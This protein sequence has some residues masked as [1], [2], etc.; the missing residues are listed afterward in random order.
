MPLRR[1]RFLLGFRVC[2]L[3][4]LLAAPA[5]PLAAQTA[6]A[7]PDTAL[8][9]FLVTMGQGDEVWEKFGHNALWIHDPVNG[10]ELA[11]N[12]GLFDF[13][14][15][16][17]WGRFAKGNW[18][19]QIGS[20]DALEMIDYYR[21]SNRS[22]W[23][24][25][26]NLTATQKREL[27]QFLQWNDLPGNRE[28]PYNYFW[29]NCS[30]RVRDALDRVLGGQI[31]AATQDSATGTTYRWHSRRLIA[32][33]KLGYTGMNAGLGP[34]A[35]HPISVW[36]EMFIPMQLQA[37]LRG[38]RVRDAAGRSVPLVAGEQQIFRAV[39]RPPER[40]APPRWIPAYLGIGVVL[41]GVL[42]GLGWA[43]GRNGLARWG[44]AALAALWTLLAGFGGIVLGLLWML[45]DHVAAHRNHNLL[46]FDPLALLLVFLIPAFAYGAR[47]AARPALWFT[48]TVAALSALGLLLKVFPAWHQV[49]G[50]IIALALPAHL[51]LLAGVLFVARAAQARSIPRT[52]R[53]RRGR[54]DLWHEEVP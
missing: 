29:D 2:A 44:F 35:D 36:E 14:A 20:A 39:D 12:Y 1:F 4:A 3:L 13:N 11:Y 30:T 23:V 46:Q 8:T 45:T 47:W 49:N 42:A 51:G 28:Y 24:Q 33:D 54:A 48:A 10:T 19:Y 22:V 5:C 9:V 16:G 31:R 25:E 27:Q 21:Q 43:A 41:G 37:H 40:S 38:V 6:S 7:A 32:E 50:E 34:V 15:P 53:T 17:Y 18:I 52:V 26:L